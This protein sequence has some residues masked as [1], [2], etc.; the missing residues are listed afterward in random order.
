[1]LMASYSR[2]LNFG[3][4][5]LSL[6]LLLYA[7]YGADAALK[8][9]A[10]MFIASKESYQSPTST[11]LKSSEAHR[12]ISVGTKRIDIIFV[13]FSS[14]YY[15][16]SWLFLSPCCYMNMSSRFRMK[17]YIGCTRIQIII[18]LR[19]TV[20]TKNEAQLRNE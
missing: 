5:F 12:G 10:S 6:L 20:G 15:Y 8:I 18:A 16:V 4:S 1:M 2:P 14:G 13:L 11:L 7:L 3:N 19:F 9:I 17:H